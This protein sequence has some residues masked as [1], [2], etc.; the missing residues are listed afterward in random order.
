MK[1]KLLFTLFNLLGLI[2]LAQGEASNWYFGFNSGIKFDLASNSVSSLSN[3][4]IDTYEGSASISDEFG[5]LL[6]YTDGITVWNKNHNVMSNGSNLY[7]DPSS[8]QSA[9]IVPKPNNNDIYYIFTV[10]DHNN[11]EFHYGLNYSEVDITLDNGLGKVT[12]KNTNLLKDCS[13][14]ITAVLK[15]CVTQAI[16][17]IGFAS[18]DGNPGELDTFYAFEVNDTGI[19]N[20]PVKSTFTFPPN[21]FTDYRGYLKLSPDGTKLASSNV[22]NGLFLYDFDVSTGLVSN[23]LP[24][25]ISGVADKAYGLEFSPNSELL[26]VNAYNDFNS[27]DYAENED[28]TNHKSQLLQYN[29][30]ATDIVGSAV[31]LDNRQLF[32][33]GLQLA[34]NGKIYRALS[35]TYSQGL[36]F[37]GAINNPNE[38]GLASN[39]IHNA[40]SIAP[41][42]SSQGLPPF[43]Q[44]FFNTKIDIIKNNKNTINLDLCEHESYTLTADLI[45]G[46]SIPGATYSWSLNGT[47][48]AETTSE[49][50]IDKSGHYE[51]Y[52]DPN[53]GDCALEGEA[54]VNY[55]N[56]PIAFDYTLLQCDEDAIADGITT[57]VLNKANEALTG[58]NPDLATKF[59]TDAARTK[60]VDGAEYINI[61][62]PET[63]YVEVYNINTLCFSTSELT[64][65]VSTTGTNDAQLTECDDDG[66]EDGFHTFNLGYANT[67]IAT[68]LPAGITISY[69]ENYD[70]ALLE[71]NRLNNN[72]TNTTA[73][74]HTIYARIENANACY[75]ISE[76]LLTVN[77]LPEIDTEALTYYCT[78]KFPETITINPEI[79]NDLP[80]NFTYHWSTN[81]STYSI[82]IN[83]V[84]NYDVTVTNAN[85]CSKTQTITVEGVSIATINNIEV[86][87]ISDNNMIT[88]FATGDGIYEYQLL[89]ENATMVVAPYQS[90]P[91]FENVFPGIYTVTVKDT[92]NDCG[93]IMETAYVIGFPKFFTPNSDGYHDTWKVYGVS[94]DNQ[95]NSKIYIYNRYGKLLKA[96]TPK[97]NGWN[98]SFKGALLPADDYWFVILLEDGRTYKNHFS[99]KR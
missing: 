51:V 32:R 79:T 45:S 26:Y 81:E 36:T 98:G 73:Y 1:K 68:G 20:T 82:E 29:L 88:V 60:E 95:P 57:F 53:N 50:F 72:Y 47:P 43:I 8:T 9:I 25:T 41:N 12:T 96:L 6:F 65:A 54:Y 28:P 78:N 16:W 84:G 3:G 80:E 10:D 49:L 4:Q 89:D 94:A 85:G 93:E 52:I 70:D 97:N 5:N 46:T 83:S 55:Y 30:L 38:I 71:K 86:K 63:I 27:I 23:Q 99:L 24:I 77:K 67:Q 15:D 66:I 33:G 56:N 75:G 59:F 61:A 31:I 76:V 87:D 14:K 11:Q 35:A 22:Q 18:K 2:L 44:S 37:L 7:G 74:S 40:I 39:Y 91:I 92:K 21:I 58:N 48:L 69:Y 90:S 42:L 17:V 19:Q 34:P 13:E 62:N 64:L